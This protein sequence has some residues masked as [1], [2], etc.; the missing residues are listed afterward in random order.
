[1]MS[2]PYTCF[3]T[4]PKGY[5]DLVY[6]GHGHCKICSLFGRIYGH[7]DEEEICSDCFELKYIKDIN[8]KKQSELKTIREKRLATKFFETIEKRIRKG[9]SPIKVRR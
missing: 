7:D 9:W 1:M 3:D 5:R 4:L 6:K 2:K 8:S